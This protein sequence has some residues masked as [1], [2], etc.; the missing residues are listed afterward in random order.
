[1]D[2]ACCSS[3]SAKA[4]HASYCLILLLPA[5]SLNPRVSLKRS[6]RQSAFN[7]A[8]VEGETFFLCEILLERN[9]LAAKREAV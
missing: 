4:F 6:I 2:Y 3:P 9:Q 5:L 8:D 7:N 1:M